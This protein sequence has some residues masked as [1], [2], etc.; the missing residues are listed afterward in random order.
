MI[1]AGGGV[2]AHS[3]REAFACG[4]ALMREAASGDDAGRQQEL[5]EGA[6]VLERRGHGSRRFEANLA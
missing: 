1:A 2:E 3:R 4:C 6:T 5:E